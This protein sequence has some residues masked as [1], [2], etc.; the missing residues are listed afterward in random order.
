MKNFSYLTIRAEGIQIDRQWSNSFSHLS[1]YAHIGNRN[2]ST[3][4]ILSQVINI[5]LDGFYRLNIIPSD[6]IIISIRW[7]VINM[8]SQKII[9]FA[10]AK[11][12]N[13]EVKDSIMAIYKISSAALIVEYIK[14]KGAGYTFKG[15]GAGVG[16]DLKEELP[17]WIDSERKLKETINFLAS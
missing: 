17:G 15:V 7:E 8:A 12:F 6:I 2:I 5:Y 13:I 16:A 9:A 14:C 11:G 4:R 10:K 1:D 3:T